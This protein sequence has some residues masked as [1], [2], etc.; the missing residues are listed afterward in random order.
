MPATAAQWYGMPPAHSLEYL[1]HQALRNSDPHVAAAPGQ[2]LAS[3]PQDTGPTAAATTPRALAA[4]P[5]HPHMF[6]VGEHTQPVPTFAELLAQANVD[7][8][9][10][11]EGGAGNSHAPTGGLDAAHELSFGAEEGL[12]HG[13]AEGQRGLEFLNGKL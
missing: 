7:S 12:T 9:R 4:P 2:L 3:A 13:E 11:G 8:Q 10:S 6:G 1:Y 5:H